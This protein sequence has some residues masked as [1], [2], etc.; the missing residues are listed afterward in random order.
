[1][2]EFDWTL[3]LRDPYLG[4]LLHGL[5]LTLE[6]AAISSVA[7]FAL[8]VGVAIMRLSRRAVARAL[9]AGFVEVFRNVPTLFWLLFFFYVVPNLAPAPTADAINRWPDLA[10][11]AAICALTLSNGAHLAEILRSGFSSLPRTHRLVGLALGLSPARVWLSVLLPQALRVSLPALGP[12]M[13]HN[14]HL[15]ALAML[16]SVPELT[17]QT[18]QIESITFRGFEAVTI[19][20]FAFIAL[21]LL[22]TLAFRVAE[23]RLRRWT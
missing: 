19:A 18:Q 11:W 23:H 2:Y 4:W 7:S 8:G 12:R 22:V 9:A 5:R 13:V 21:S 1:M 15:T 17:W 10:F 6:L 3:P 20:S 14:L 16:A